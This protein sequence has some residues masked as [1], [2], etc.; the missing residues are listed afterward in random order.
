MVGSPKDRA[1]LLELM[2]QR[3]ERAYGDKY[4]M[5]EAALCAAEEAGVSMQPLPE[6]KRK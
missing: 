2:V 1:A 6:M 3:H 5:M 4:A